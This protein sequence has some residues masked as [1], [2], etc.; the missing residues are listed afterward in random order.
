MKT[1]TTTASFHSQAS[2]S[3]HSLDELVR[4]A[5]N[6]GPALD[7]GL[8]GIR[9]RAGHSSERIRHPHKSKRNH[10]YGFLSSVASRGCGPHPNTITPADSS[11]ERRA[12]GT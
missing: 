2:E 1:S 12:P 6:T 5:P 11:E 4:S 7:T 3:T 9:P 8:V 10:L